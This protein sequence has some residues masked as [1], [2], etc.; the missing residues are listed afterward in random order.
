MGSDRISCRV[1]SIY[2]GRVDKLC[3]RHVVLVFTCDKIPILQYKTLSRT[4]TLCHKPS[5]LGISRMRHSG[6]LC[7]NEDARNEPYLHFF[8]GWTIG[9]CAVF[10]QEL[11]PSLQL[12][13]HIRQPSSRLWNLKAHMSW[14]LFC[15]QLVC[16]VWHSGPV[17]QNTIAQRSH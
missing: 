11:P 9:T 3:L 14:S 2:V 17:A 8:R 7:W 6:P 4:G 12:V 16:T 15:P 10:L 13:A 1:I 5:G